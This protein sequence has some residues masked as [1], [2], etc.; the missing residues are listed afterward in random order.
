MDV[1]LA[2]RN[3]GKVS[4][5][6]ELLG[7]LNLNIRSL[8]DFEWLGEV[9]ETGRSFEE[10]AVKKATE[11]ADATGLVAIADD[12]GLLVDALGGKPGVLSARY[13]GEN[14]TDSENNEK[15]LREL[16]G[17]PPEKRSARFICVI[18]VAEPHGNCITV[19]EECVGCITLNPSGR[20]GFG[21]DPI[22]YLPIVGRTMAELPPE[23]KNVMSHRAKAVSELKKILPDFL[24]QL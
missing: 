9:E 14:A 23:E 7:D 6:K 20:G 8:C 13:A 3:R 5:F 18:A 11:V 16:E 1:V 15:I 19:S 12:S 22:F 10:N 24:A 4:E 21:Y 2:T 17:I